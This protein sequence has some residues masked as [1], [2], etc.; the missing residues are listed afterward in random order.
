M[1]KQHTEDCPMWK[2][3]LLG[4]DEYEEDP[5]CE[6]LKAQI[7]DIENLSQAKVVFEEAQAS[8]KAVL[9]IAPKEHAEG[10]VEQLI[11]ADPMVYSEIEEE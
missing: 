8:G 5:V 7:P 11:R 4:D 9:L 3:L 2:V 6:V 10:Y 1:P